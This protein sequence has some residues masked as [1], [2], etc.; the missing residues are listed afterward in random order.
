MIKE[1]KKKQF[2]KKHMHA[3]TKNNAQDV[4]KKI[5]SRFGRLRFA[6]V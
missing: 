5:F 2:A 4:V 1:I 3:A 6:C